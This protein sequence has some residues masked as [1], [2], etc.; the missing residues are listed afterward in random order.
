MI[1]PDEI[2]GAAQRI[3][4]YV[5]RTPVIELQPGAFLSDAPLTL[6]LE[7]L[8]HTGS[9]KPRGAFNRVLSHNVKS[10]TL[11]AAS[12]GNH[13]VAVAYVAKRLG[14]QAEIFV[15]TVSSPVKVQ[16]LRDYGATVRIV[17]DV[18]AD[19][20]EA[21]KERASQPDAF[22]V[23]AYDQPEVV[24]GAGTLGFELEQQAPQLDTVLVACGGGGLIAGVASWYA[25]KARVVSVEPAACPTLYAAREAG[26]PVDVQTGGV[27]GDSLAARRLGGIAFEVTSAHVEQAVLVS[28]EAISDAQRRLWNELRVV[29]EPGGATALAAV[30]S[31][32]YR[33]SPG[34]RVGVVV[35]GGNADLGA[36]VSP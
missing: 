8:Q 9:F 31:G 7:S 13:G 18:Y 1:A 14:L 6:K 34:E 35:C 2:R 30:L 20:L 29:A 32:A 4:A 3:A 26:K 5:R 21:S 33:P 12:G 16:R 28:E 22:E 24:A 25:G 10:G 17:G 23:H 36:L 27:A 11:V 19:S 15:P